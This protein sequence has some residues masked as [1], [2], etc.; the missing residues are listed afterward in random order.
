MFGDP[1]NHGIIRKMVVLFGNLF[2]NLFI[3]R[4]KADGTE[5]ERTKV[6]LT[7]APKE[8]FIVRIQ[9][10]PELTK[11]IMTTLPRLSYE[12]SAYEYDP[13]RKLASI[14]RDSSVNANDSSKKFS[15]YTGVPYNFTFRLYLYARNIE[16]GTQVIEQILP[17]FTPDYTMTAIF[18]DEM[19][20]KKD[21][22][23]ILKSVENSIDYEGQIQGIPRLITWT[24]EFTA[25]GW[26]F[27]PVANTSIIKGVQTGNTVTGGINIGIYQMGKSGKLQYLTVNKITPQGFLEG[28]SITIDSRDMVGKIAGWNNTSNKLIVSDIGKNINSGDILRGV[29][30]GAY[31]TA[32]TISFSETKLSDIKIYQD[33]ITAN[34]SSD[35]GYTTYIEEYPNTL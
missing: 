35:Y 9:S 24:L 19:N 25:K 21:I 15:Q 20:I 11:S 6:L 33:P 29:I 8:K 30:S 23:F 28:E 10:D 32:N 18:V 4:K 14:I 3:I 16:D 2:D 5:L 13:T 22:P 12:L 27:G 1:F 31:A 26:F 7:Y 34:A 17:Y